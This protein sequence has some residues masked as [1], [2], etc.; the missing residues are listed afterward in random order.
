[1]SRGAGGARGNAL[2]IPPGV[3]HGFQVL[4]D[5]TRVLY[6]M[7]DYYAPG[8]GRRRALRRPGLRD[9][10][11][12]AGEPDHAARPGLPGLRPGGACPP[13]RRR[14]A[15]GRMTRVAGQGASIARPTAPIARRWPRRPSGWCA[16]FTRSVAASPATG[17]AGRWIG[18]ARSCRWS[19]ARCRAARRCSTGRFRANG[20][21]GP[22]GSRVRTAARWWILPITTLHLVSYSAPFRGRM[23]SRGAAPP[24]AFHAGAS[25]TGFPYRTS[26]YAE[27]WGFC[28]RHRDLEALAPGEYEVVVDTTLAPGSLSYA[29]ALVPGRSGREALIY[30]HTCHPS[31]ANDNLTGVAVAAALLARELMGANSSWAGAS[32][33]GPARSARWPGW[34]RTRRGWGSIAHGLV[35]GLLGDPGP[36]TYKASR[37]GD[38]VVD[39]A[40]RYPAAAHLAPAARLTDFEPYGYDERQFCSPGFD[41]PVGRLTRSPNGCYPSTTARRTT[42]SW[43]GCR[44][45]PSPS[46]AAAAHRDARR[47]RT[48]LNLSPERRAA[49]RQARPL[50][51]PGR[52][53]PGELQQACCGCSTSPTARRDLL[54][55]AERSGLP[56]DEIEQAASA[57]EE[58]GL[59]Q[60]LGRGRHQHREDVVKVVLFCG[61]LGTRLREHS[62]TVPKPLVNIGYRPILWHLMRYYA[63][64]GHKEFILASATAAT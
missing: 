8:A 54:A 42:R 23:R 22:P 21:S 1:M 41:L 46:C 15:G 36:L 33:S 35:I 7:T 26:Y 62:D 12:L 17:C 34:R 61:G 3:A 39:R 30:T 63:H 28:L 49:P 55:I 64:Y 27:D 19:G 11:A 56:F 14:R 13:A 4:E 16:S 52:A 45:S 57:L 59:L 40:A 6:L 20:T 47:N 60:A 50:R 58:A 2:F 10:L 31:L 51:Q 48:C 44:T 38:A 25:R 43:S 37:R 9:R 29:E 5:D 24:P 18:W 32:C 53:A